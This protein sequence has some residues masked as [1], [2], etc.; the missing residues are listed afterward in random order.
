MIPPSQIL[1]KS[2]LSQNCFN[3]GGEEVRNLL[4]RFL[5]FFFPPIINLFITVIPNKF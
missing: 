4:T 2:P 3:R 1:L 5:N